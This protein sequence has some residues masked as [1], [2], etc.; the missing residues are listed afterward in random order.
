MFSAEE[1]RQACSSSNSLIFQHESVYVEFEAPGRQSNGMV[2]SEYFTS[3]NCHE[4]LIPPENFAAAL[5][6][7]IE[8][9]FPLEGFRHTNGANLVFTQFLSAKTN[10][11]DFIIRG[12]FAYMHPLWIFNFHSGLSTASYTP[13]TKSGNIQLKLLAWWP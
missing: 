4:F 2:T 11:H 5:S 13:F 7:T 10:C 12:I 6:P 3:S 1:K 8:R 9:V